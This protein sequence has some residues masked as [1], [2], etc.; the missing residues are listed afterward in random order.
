MTEFSLQVE[1]DGAQA[2]LSCVPGETVTIYW[3]VRE[4]FLKTKMSKFLFDVFKC[5]G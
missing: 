2:V 4:G 1:E 5:D 3:L